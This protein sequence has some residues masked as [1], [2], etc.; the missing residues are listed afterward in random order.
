MQGLQKIIFHSPPIKVLDQI[1]IIIICMLENAP[2]G[3]I[4]WCAARF[5]VCI[6]TT[7]YNIYEI[8]R[9]I[10]IPALGDDTMPTKMFKSVWVRHAYYNEDHD[11]YYYDDCNL[12]RGGKVDVVLIFPHVRVQ[13]RRSGHVLLILK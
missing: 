4:E 13:L 11:Y 1:I 12:K 2:K 9:I 3:R 10:I 8:I 7:T 5:Y 6:C